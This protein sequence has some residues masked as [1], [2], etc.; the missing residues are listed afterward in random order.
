M[1][2][3]VQQRPHEPPAQ[4]ASAVARYRLIRQSARVGGASNEVK[5]PPSAQR[6][7]SSQLRPVAVRRHRQQLGAS[8]SPVTCLDT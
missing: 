4:P 1:M 8:L 6:R 2:A 3:C 5:T 7:F